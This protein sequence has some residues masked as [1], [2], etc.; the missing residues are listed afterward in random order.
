M[1]E[2]KA[3][4]FKKIPGNFGDELNNFI[5]KELFDIKICHTDEFNCDLIGIGSI[6]GKILKPI[7]T[8]FINKP[9][10][11]WGSGFILPYASGRKKLIRPLILHAIR[12]KLTEKALNFYNISYTKKIYGD[13]GLL[14][15]KIFNKTDSQQEYDYGIIPHYVD[16][17][18]T[19]LNKIK[20]KNFC[21]IDP[22]LPVKEVVIKI[23]KCKKILSSAMHGLIAADAFNIPN[24]RLILSDNIIGGDHK[25]NDYYSAFEIDN[26]LKLDLRQD[27]EIT[28]KNLKF[29]YSI[30]EK[31]ITNIQNQL[32]ESFPF[33]C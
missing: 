6:L 20:L 31:A 4:Y 33:K 16:L 11:I 24:M 3:Y 25:Y 26:H 27:I 8:E 21:I 9:V 28:D 15:S 13:P 23:L 29:N 7:D 12:G 2:I 17:T 32:I 5:L 10:H 14:L 1:K 30:T 22:T 18:N 19:N